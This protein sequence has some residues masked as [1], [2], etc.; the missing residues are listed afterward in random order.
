MAK[1]IFSLGDE[2]F[3][4]LLAEAKT[5]DISIQE[6][7]RAVII[8]SWMKDNLNARTHTDPTSILSA[9]AGHLNQRTG[10]LPS[11]IGRLKP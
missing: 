1:F 3:R 9:T 5:R 7:I 6:L 10:V 8:P 4:L 2:N 11:S